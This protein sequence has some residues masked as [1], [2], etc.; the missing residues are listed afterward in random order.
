MLIS[1]NSPV[2]FAKRTLIPI[3]SAPGVMPEVPYGYTGPRSDWTTSHDPYAALCAGYALDAYT[4]WS[5]RKGTV[6][7]WNPYQGLGQP[8]LSNYWS[9][10]LYPPNWLHLILPPAWWDMVYLLNWLLAAVFLYAYLR[11]LGVEKGPSLVGSALIFSN[12]YFQFFLA[13]RE[14]PAVVA[15]WPLLLYGV[16]RAIRE[17]TWPA[18][19]WVLAFSVYCSIAGGHPEA[20]FMSLFVVLVY[21]LI[22]LATRPRSAWRAFIAIVPGSLA[23]LLTAAPI[24]INFAS[25]A[26]TNYS[27]HPAG[28][29]FGQ[30]HLGFKTLAT[31]FFPYIYG[32]LHFMPY[33]PITGWEWNLSPGWFPVMGLFLALVSLSLLLKKPRWGPGFLWV[34]ATVMIAKIWGVPGI[35]LLGRLPLFERI[36]FSKYGGFLPAIALAGLA[37]YGIFA[38]S[39]LEARRWMPWVLSWFLLVSATLIMGILPIWPAL[40]QGDL[41]SGPFRT[42]SVFGGLGVAWA[43]LGPLGLWWLKYRRPDENGLLYSLAACGI[44]FQGVAYACNGYSLYTYGLLS[45]CCL[46]TYLLLALAFGFVRKIQVSPLLIG[47]ELVLIAL[48]S[49][50]AAFFASYGLP[51]RYNPLTP[52]PYLGT[53]LKLQNN[54][55]YR[56]YSLDSIPQPNF[57]APFGLTSLDNLEALSPVGS[58]EFI[59]T[60]LDRGVFP[61]WFAGNHSAARKPEFTAL[62]E[63]FEN[64]RYFELVGVKYLVT[65]KTGPDPVIYE[66]KGSRAPLPLY[67]PLEATFLCPTDSFTEIEVYLSTYRRK[68]P[69]I[70][71]LSVL[72]PD[73]TL[74]GRDS[75]PGTSLRDNSFQKFD[76]APIKSFKDK[77]LRLRLEF[78]PKQPGSMIAAWKFLDHPDWGFFFR[79][80]DRTKRPQFPPLVLYG[81]EGLR[82]PL[83][84]DQPLE[85]TF[86]CPTDSLTDIEVYLSTHIRTNPGIVTLSVFSPDGTLL[87]RDSV[88][89]TSLRDNSFQK[90]DFAPIK[91]F[92]DQQLRLRL[93]FQ[94]KQ[95]GSMI[96][97]WKF[98]DHS[99]WGFFFRVV[100]RTKRLPLVYDDETGVCI[101]ENRQANPRVF[102]APVA[103]V[104]SSWQDALNRLKDTPNLTWQVWL[105]QGPGM[106]STWPSGKPTGRL[107]SFHLAPNDVWIKYRADTSGIL[108][109]TDSYLE[110]WH[111]EVNGQEVPVLRVDGAFRGVRVRE[112]GLYTVHFWYRPLYWNLS[113]GMA[114]LGLVLVMGGNFLSYRK[115]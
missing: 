32:R 66:R 29:S 74:L 84:L 62:G 8:L 5:L 98:L 67:Q 88:P 9:A 26:F 14:I 68:N 78:Q 54:N 19:H 114:G 96:A 94:P 70:V 20:T 93:E 63:F 42:L 24:W 112:P 49:L 73:G 101:W 81:K 61:I 12:G 82:A 56:S 83:P 37:V 106:E 11:L 3:T 16:E 34:T 51:L 72:G 10:V 76:F 44:L 52:A 41:L 27:Q 89:G 103:G 60:Y 17:P 30:L 53:L 48:L 90:F 13:V 87:G 115:R 47:L 21:A 86:L 104:V 23:G 71:T 108:T 111:A 75:V 1:V 113:L 55:L 57:A 2:F 43:V 25:Y 59:Q 18:R 65:M 85:A 6:P 50:C 7:F 91:G 97:A 95:P 33:G 39:K 110:G 77:Q 64:K 80:V 99:D 79:V 107:L 22:R 15:W 105:D 31:Y 35:D 109:V 38:L 40:K 4:A 45:S 102:L 58:A 46:V 28:S 100:D 36:W 92:K 69:G